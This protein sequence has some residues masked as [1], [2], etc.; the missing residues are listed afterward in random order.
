MKTEQIIILV[1]AFFLGMLLLNMV[2]NVCGCELKEG[3]ELPPSQ[4][5]YS[6]QII[7]CNQKINVL[8]P[9]LEQRGVPLTPL[10]NDEQNA[11]CLEKLGGDI[12]DEDIDR[13]C[14]LN[15]YSPDGRENDRDVQVTDWFMDRLVNSQNRRIR[16]ACSSFTDFASF[17]TAVGVDE[18]CDPPVPACADMIGDDTTALAGNIATRMSREGPVIPSN[19]IWPSGAASSAVMGGTVKLTCPQN[20]VAITASGDTQIQESGLD[21]T[22]GADG[23]NSDALL[24]DTVTCMENVCLNGTTPCGT[25]SDC[26]FIG[27]TPGEDSAPPFECNCQEGYFSQDG[28]NCQLFQ[29]INTAEAARD[30]GVPVLNDGD[31]ITYQSDFD[32]GEYSGDYTN[33]NLR[34]NLLYVN[35]GYTWS[36]DPVVPIQ[37]GDIT[38][39][40][41]S[42]NRMKAYGWY[43]ANGVCN[44]IK[45]NTERSTLHTAFRSDMGESGL[46]Y[47]QQDVCTDPLAR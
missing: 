44:P 17:K 6:E 2:K 3:F 41:S 8:G 36:N 27:S 12:C 14:N 4:S 7:G 28:A 25:N 5:E 16:T 30:G 20:F 21:L 23:W 22:C 1:V 38:T 42:D 24:D 11:A 32:M 15:I 26:N 18:K 9:L 10:M 45:S 43:G 40:L 33:D 39:L 13:L 34:N 35:Q 31:D 19:M 37:Q 29:S 46:C 47:T